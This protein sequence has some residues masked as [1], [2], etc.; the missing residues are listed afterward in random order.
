MFVSSDSTSCHEFA[1]QFGLA[2]FVYA[3]NMNKLSQKPTFAHLAVE[4]TSGAGNNAVS[5]GHG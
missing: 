5:D 1:S 2:F 4:W 3:K